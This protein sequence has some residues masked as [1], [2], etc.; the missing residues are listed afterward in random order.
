[1]TNFIICLIKYTTIFICILYAYTQLLRIKLKVWDLFD[2][3]LFAAL[4]AVL[5][6]VT[7]YVKI[8]VPLGLLMFLLRFCFAF[9]KICLRND[10]GR[11]DS[12]LGFQ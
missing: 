11:C 9:Q 2:I 12:V 5:Y 3:P 10:Y 4:S 8:F 1:M 7:A 6:F